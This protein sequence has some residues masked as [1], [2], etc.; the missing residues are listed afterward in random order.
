MDSLS[1]LASMTLSSVFWAGVGMAVG[2]SLPILA[3]LS[4]Y[5]YDGGIFL[6]YAIA[7]GGAV[8]G[9]FSIR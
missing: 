6:F 8:Y 3:S 9:A 1:K 2:H 7:I 4:G 5:P